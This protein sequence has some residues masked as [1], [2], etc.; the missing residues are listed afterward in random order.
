MYSFSEG[1]TYPF[2]IYSVA[3]VE[4]DFIFKGIQI[5]GKFCIEPNAVLEIPISA[6]LP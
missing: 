2:F 4:I 3:S 1:E 6:F 5:L